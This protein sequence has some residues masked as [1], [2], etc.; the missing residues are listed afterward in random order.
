MADVV[1]PHQTHEVVK[2]YYSEEIQSNRQLKT[3]ACCTTNTLPPRHR[4]ILAM[5]EPEIHEKFYGCGSPIPEALE[6]CTV[7]DLGCGTGRDVYLAS[8]LV[9]PEGRVIGVD[10]TESQLAVARKYVDTHTRR[11]GYSRPNVEFRH[12]YIEDLRSAG[13]EDNSV[14]VVISNCVVNLAADKEAVFREVLRVLKPGG[15]LYF[16]DIFSGRRIPEHLRKDPVLYGECLSGALYIEDFR[17]M[18]LR[19][20]V[21]DYRVVSSRPVSLDNP[22]VEEK[23]G[24]VDF[25]SMT[26][27]VFKL[28]SL[29]DRCEDYGQMAVYRG[30]IPDAPH[31]FVLDDHHVFITGKPMLVCGN[32]AAMLSETRFAP[33]FQVVGD[34]SVH[35]GLFDCKPAAQAKPQAAENVGGSCC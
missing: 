26:I 35:Y 17:R 28:D 33:H 25:Y 34:R 4:E 23:I 21:L 1:A 27:R 2:K 19:L 16:S 13:I 9:G 15:E 20:G 30:S 7:L 22:E 10:M 31:R 29:E 18:L 8:R 32:T 3:S 6:G 5:I 12:G 11:F 24:M 14:D